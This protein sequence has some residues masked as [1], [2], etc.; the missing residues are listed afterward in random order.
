M[1]SPNKRGKKREK[2][3]N[4]PK[5]ATSA[6][7]YFLSDCRE[8]AK[9]K[10][11][12]ISKIAEFTKE[13][14]ELWKNMGAGQ[15]KK[16]DDMA[17]ADKARYDNEMAKYKGKSKV[18][19]GKPKKPQTA[20]FLFLADFR[21]KMKGKNI[22]HKEILKLAGEEW[23]KLSQAE[24]APYDKGAQEEQRKY[25]VKLAEW[26]KGGGGAVSAAKKARQETNGAGAGSTEEEDDDE[27]EE[28]DDD[29]EEE[30]SD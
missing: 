18:D 4:K 6:Y 9:R 2:D 30:E 17:A 11:K 28:E 14:S 7:F 24:R 1:D 5:R 10:G 19:D 26:R 22:E 25:E 12:S 8:E 16:F 3:P 29:E 21:V 20:Y 27:E 13:C 15:K 23:K